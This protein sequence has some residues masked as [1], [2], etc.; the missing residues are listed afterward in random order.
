MHNNIL[1]LAP[2]TFAPTVFALDRKLFSLSVGLSIILCAAMS[3]LL[4]KA[5]CF[6]LCS[7][8]CRV[9]KHI[10][11]NAWKLP[12]EHR[13]VR[14]FGILSLLHFASVSEWGCYLQLVPK[15][16]FWCVGSV[17]MKSSTMSLM[18]QLPGR[19]HAVLE[20][21]CPMEHNICFH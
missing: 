15:D 21:P 19:Q 5:I 11:K 10:K 1:C 20:M 17:K 14:A 12:H 18:N 6:F 13:F 16:Y 9:D 3:G 4:K 7:S 2:P 8:T